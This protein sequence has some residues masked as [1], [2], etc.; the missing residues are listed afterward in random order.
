M[1]AFK[2][3]RVCKIIAT[4]IT[5]T[6]GPRQKVEDSLIGTTTCMIHMIVSVGKTHSQGVGSIQ[7]DT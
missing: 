5:N 7:I 2:E 1:K 3:I 6:L 4:P